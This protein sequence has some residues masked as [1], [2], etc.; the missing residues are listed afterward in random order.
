M[1][2]EIRKCEK[3]GRELKQ[4][5]PYAH[6]KLEG[7]SAHKELDEINFWCTNE[8]CENFNKNIKLIE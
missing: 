8:D 6:V 1:N 7:E 5:G 4:S 2:N 3:C